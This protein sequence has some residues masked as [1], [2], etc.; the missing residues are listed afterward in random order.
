VGD[1]ESRLGDNMTRIH[2]QARH[3]YPAGFE[4]AAEFEAAAGVTALYGPSGGGKTTIL[5]IIAGTLRPDQASV[6]LD[7]QIL[8]DSARQIIL[9]PDRRHIGCVFQDQR[10]F[11]HLT[12]ESNLRYGLAR[13][14]SR[15]VDFAKVVEVLDLGNLL[16]RYPVTL[17][18]GQQQRV[19]LGRAVLS[20]P[21][22]LLLD[23]PLTALDAN[24]KDRVVVYLE[25][26]LKEWRIPTLFV[27]HDQLDVRRF[28][29]HA[30]VVHAGKVVAAGPTASTLD[31]TLLGSE[32]PAA[33]PINLIRIDAARVVDG[34]LIADVNG[35]HLYLPS[36]AAKI[37][38]TLYVRFL[39][40]DV[41]LSR[42]PIAGI[43]IRNQLRGTVS[44]LV[45][46]EQ[47]IFVKIDIGQII[48]AE[49]TAG[50][51]AEL[52]LAEGCEVTCLIKATA[53]QIVN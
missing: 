41:T 13:G 43:S 9:P 37:Q 53:L 23:E 52:N 30:V 47:D 12:I 22:L 6:I 33:A 5:G 16:D 40:S 27:S 15:P 3:R 38:S 26:L 45:R 49:V 46:K 31:R 11:P 19:A 32:L 8:V 42:T 14:T 51:A 25:Y 7:D 50:A 17:S 34:H 4:L 48:W 28:A 29:A 1:D 36:H 18:G 21:K 2:F 24:L 44:E 10:L 35:Q 39:P 20:G